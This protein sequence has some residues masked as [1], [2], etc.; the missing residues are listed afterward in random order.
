MHLMGILT[1]I[2]GSPN[3]QSLVKTLGW[4]EK[5]ILKQHFQMHFLEWKI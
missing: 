4:E 5:Y 2:F 1:I 3:Y